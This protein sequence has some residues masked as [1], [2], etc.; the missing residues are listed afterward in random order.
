MGFFLN[1]ESW[2]KSVEKL[3]NTEILLWELKLNSHHRDR[4]CSNEW[5]YVKSKTRTGNACTQS[6]RLGWNIKAGTEYSGKN[7]LWSNQHV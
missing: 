3:E 2:E 6:W 5:S 7:W 1:S 4:Y